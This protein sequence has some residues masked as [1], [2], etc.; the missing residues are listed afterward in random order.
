MFIRLP[1][2][3]DIVESE[4]V[5]GVTARGY[6]G[7]PSAVTIWVGTCAEGQEVSLQVFQSFEVPSL[8]R[9]QQVRDQIIDLC[10][11]GVIEGSDGF[12]PKDALL[13]EVKDDDEDSAEGM[14]RC[15]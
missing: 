10:G 6:R 12:D 14:I 8:A 5:A 4:S 7:F 2:C 13:N 1:V 9:A 15:H 11:I 3:G